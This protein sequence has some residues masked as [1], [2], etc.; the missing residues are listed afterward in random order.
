MVFTVPPDGAVRG[1]PGRMITT[2]RLLAP[3]DPEAPLLVVATREEAEHLGV[4]VPVL[5]TG[6]GRINATGA[7]AETL[8]RGP[9][10]TSILNV[11]TAGALRD[12]GA[13]GGPLTGVHRIRQVRLHDFSHS[14]VRRLTGAD[15]YPPIDLLAPP[16]RAGAA[17]SDGPLSD[18]PALVLATGDVFVEDSVTRAQLAEV[19]DLVDME[20]YAIAWVARRFGVP[21]ELVKLVSDPADESAGKLWA[22][23][24]AECSRLLGS[25]LGERFG[26]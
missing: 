16:A 7:L 1:Y 23:G 4:D 3:V 12:K 21:V 25:H 5:L 11:G 9:L 14:A 24:V 17:L 22:A 19:G 13:D 15:A 6:I 18:D 2:S 10:P 8:A 20:G 26:A